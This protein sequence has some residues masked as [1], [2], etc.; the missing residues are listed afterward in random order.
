M[1]INEVID[2]GM[3]LHIVFGEKHQRLVVFSL[4]FQFVAV[5]VFYLAMCG[6][7]QTQIDTPAGMEGGKQMLTGAAVE[8]CPEYLKTLYPRDRTL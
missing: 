2:I 4:V 7:G 8:Y 5:S 6:P 1:S 3:G